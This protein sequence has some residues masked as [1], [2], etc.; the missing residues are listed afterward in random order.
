[1]DGYGRNGVLVEDLRE[2]E[3]EEVFSRGEEAGLRGPISIRWGRISG[4]FEGGFGAIFC[5]G[6]GGAMKRGVGTTF[7]GLTSTGLT[8]TGL[9][10]LTFTGFKALVLRGFLEEPRPT[11]RPGMAGGLREMRDG[12][13]R[14]QHIKLS[15]GWK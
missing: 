10:T 5:G 7:P 1:M 3:D 6:S 9:G 14:G 15:S 11:L 2:G 8:L 4:V 12:E 13:M